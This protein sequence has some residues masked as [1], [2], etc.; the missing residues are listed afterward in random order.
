MN[1]S[2]N[3]LAPG[4]GGRVVSIEGGYRVQQRLRTLGLVEGA[5]VRKL[6]ALAWGGPVVVEVSRT[7][8]AVGRGLA[9]RVLVEV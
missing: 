3:D 7:Q 9:R 2:L 5:A 6:S 8:V 1:R 4:E